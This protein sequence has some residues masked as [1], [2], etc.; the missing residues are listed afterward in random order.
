MAAYEIT[1][2]GTASR[3]LEAALDGMEVT[4]FAGHT[5]L[6]GHLADQAALRGLLD[7]LAALHL[8]V[9]S[10]RRL[11]PVEAWDATGP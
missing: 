11:P 2:K 7:R 3:R 1:V 9:V 10:L 5:V 8:D 6:H 4:S